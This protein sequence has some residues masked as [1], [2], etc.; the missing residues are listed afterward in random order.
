MDVQEINIE[1]NQFVQRLE[2]ILWRMETL[3]N[4]SGG[5]DCP[6]VT[7]AQRSAVFEAPDI[8]HELAAPRYRVMRNAKF[9]NQVDETT[10]SVSYPLRPIRGFCGMPSPMRPLKSPEI[11]LK[12]VDVYPLDHCREDL[13]TRSLPRGSIP[14]PYPSLD[15][16][17]ARRLPVSPPMYEEATRQ[18]TSGR[19]VAPD[20]SSA[21]VRWLDFQPIARLHVN[22]YIYYDF[23]H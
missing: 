19:R 21:A 10:V 23:L 5:T 18:S 22:L 7:E 9:P 11:G 6:G 15:L 16:F 4:F 1:Q 8:M 14:P 17:H 12:L 3:L 13:P 2:A 20:L